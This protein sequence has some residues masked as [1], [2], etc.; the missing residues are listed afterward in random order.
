MWE[1]IVIMVVNSSL[2]LIT[3]SSV[4]KICYFEKF[5]WEKIS[6][7]APVI[8][9]DAAV[10]M[11]QHGKGSQNETEGLRQSVSRYLCVIL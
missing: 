11:M 9:C 10:T 5:Q 2:I 8:S 6:K 1:L 7:L 4:F 3:L